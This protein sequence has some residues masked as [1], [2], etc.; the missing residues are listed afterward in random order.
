MTNAILF[1]DRSGEDW[2]R[3]GLETKR[4]KDVTMDLSVDIER[5]NKCRKVGLFLT[6]PLPNSGLDRGVQIIGEPIRMRDRLD[7][8]LLKKLEVPLDRKDVGINDGGNR[9]VRYHGVLLPE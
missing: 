5:I 2:L 1:I 7:L 3:D 8:K 9:V 4:F 6:E